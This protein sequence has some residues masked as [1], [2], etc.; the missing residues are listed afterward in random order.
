VKYEPHVAAGIAETCR[1]GGDTVAYVRQHDPMAAIT[2]ELEAD[3]DFAD[4]VWD[5]A[6]YGPAM[7]L[8]GRDAGTV[9]R[10]KSFMDRI[11]RIQMTGEWA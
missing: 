4:L 9:S 8:A 7:M 11:A 1:A 6:H 2:L 5:T 10:V 3:K